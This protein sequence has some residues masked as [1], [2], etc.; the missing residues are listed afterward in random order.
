MSNFSR[1]KVKVAHS[2]FNE[3]LKASVSHSIPSLDWITHR[4]FQDIQRCAYHLW[5][6]AGRPMEIGIAD[7]FWLQAETLLSHD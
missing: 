4:D 2:H 7:H 1:L 3:K 6:L 5:E